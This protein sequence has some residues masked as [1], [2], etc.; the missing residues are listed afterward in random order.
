MQA[1]RLTG[2]FGNTV[3]S[4]CPRSASLSCCLPLT[5]PHTLRLY[6]GA[7]R[8]GCSPKDGEPWETLYRHC[9]GVAVSQGLDIAGRSSIWGWSG[10]LRLAGVLRTLMLSPGKKPAGDALERGARTQEGAGTPT[11]LF[12]LH[13]TMSS[14]WNHQ[15][16]HPTRG[17]NV[18]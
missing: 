18:A 11:N 14:K 8:A 9:P 15:L 2:A 3:V 1:E 12:L 16:R 4:V 10:P 13:P 6:L 5:A 7:V 17:F